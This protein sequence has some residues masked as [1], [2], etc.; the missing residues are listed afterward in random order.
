MSDRS[1]IDPD[2]TCDFRPE[3]ELCYN[4]ATR[5]VEEPYTPGRFKVRCCETCAAELINFGY[6]DRGSI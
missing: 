3:G 1:L 5:L 6:H 4:R 2:E